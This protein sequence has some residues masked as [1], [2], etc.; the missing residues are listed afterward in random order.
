MSLVLLAAG[1]CCWPDFR[2]TR[3]FWLPPGTQEPRHL[4]N[5]REWKAKRLCQ[6][7]PVQTECLQWAEDKELEYGVWGGKGEEE[8]GYNP[9]VIVML[10]DGT[11]M[12]DWRDDLAPCGTLKGLE[13]HAGRGEKPCG[14]CIWWAHE[15]PTCGA[16]TGIAGHIRRMEPLCDKC[17]QAH[18]EHR[19][20]T[21]RN[22][23]RVGVKP[24][25]A[26]SAED[27]GTPDGAKYHRRLGERPCSAC[28]E[29][30][31]GT[32]AGYASH[33]RYKEWTDPD[34]RAA[35]A[36]KEQERQAKRRVRTE[37]SAAKVA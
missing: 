23:A 33:L 1:I 10:D 32:D 27:C 5:E 35:H 26:L 14:P 2:N 18:S 4:R 34:C 19:N 8:R 28:C 24:K 31:C 13:G 16:P 17:R 6:A 30:I 9:P 7:C 25:G 15:P 20:G 29:F 21:E 11:P 37:A 3:H 22:L 12:R 36:A